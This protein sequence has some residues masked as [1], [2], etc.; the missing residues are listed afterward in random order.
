MTP[1]DG[2]RE[3]AARFAK[4]A[5]RPEQAAFRRRVFLAHDGAC[6]VTGC[7]I[8]EALDAAHRD[9]RNWRLGHNSAADGL[10][11]RKDIHALFDAG[12][13][14]IDASGIVT[15]HPAVEPHFRDYP[16]KA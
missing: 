5:V 8:P 13:V 6:V 7:T 1:D 14:S 9:G 4:V 2:L 15:F 3:R 11:L 10:L 16:R 12:L